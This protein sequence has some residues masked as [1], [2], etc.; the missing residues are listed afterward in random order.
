MGLIS[1][2]GMYILNQTREAMYV[3]G[4]QIVYVGYASRNKHIK[5]MI[6]KWCMVGFS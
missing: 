1:Y 4:G 6:Q 2:N 3:K 5:N